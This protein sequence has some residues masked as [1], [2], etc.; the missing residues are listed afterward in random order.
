MIIVGAVLSL[1]IG[2]DLWL[3]AKQIAALVYGP[4]A[5]AQAGFVA[6]PVIVGTLL[7]LLFAIL[8]GALFGIIKSRIFRL[9]SDMGVPVLAG[10]V[11]GTTIWLLAYFVVLPVVNPLVLQTYAPSF[12]LQNVVYGIVIG[13]VHS[14]VRPEPYLD[15]SRQAR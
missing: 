15:L 14:I 5:V 8:L 2:D 13:L 6:G 3:Q 1:V 10:L 12:I 11:Y 9:P 4:A 7:H